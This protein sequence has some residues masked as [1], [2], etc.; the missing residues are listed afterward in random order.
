MIRQSIELR[1]MKKKKNMAR[2]CTASDRIEENSKKKM[3]K[4]N[5]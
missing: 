3:K 5:Q 2:Q 4:N 1:R